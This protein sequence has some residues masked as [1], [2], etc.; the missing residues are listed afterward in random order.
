MNQS[1]G[2]LKVE[3]DF[4][5]FCF[6]EDELRE[7]SILQNFYFYE[8]LE[9]SKIYIFTNFHSEEGWIS[10]LLSDTAFAWLPRELS[11]MYKLS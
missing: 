11:C 3:L 4:V 9:Q 5:L 8:V 10:N 2:W 1:V 6:G 7:L